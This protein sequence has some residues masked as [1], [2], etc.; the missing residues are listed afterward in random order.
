V[1]AVVS[2]AS[3]AKVIREALVTCDDP[4]QAALLRSYAD[5]TRTLTESGQ[6]S[7]SLRVSFSQNYSS[8]PST[9]AVVIPLIGDDLDIAHAQ[10]PPRMHVAAW[11]R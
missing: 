7:H 5:T 11:K 8:P 1:V 3:E 9:V 10:L 4:K 2:Y 6:K